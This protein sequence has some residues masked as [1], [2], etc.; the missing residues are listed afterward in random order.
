MPELNVIKQSLDTIAD[1]PNHPKAGAVMEKLGL[2][3]T[4]VNAWKAIKDNPQ[5]PKAAE[6]KNK[7]FDRIANTLPADPVKGRFEVGPLSFNER[8]DIKNLLDRDPIAAQKFLETRVDEQGNR[9]YVARVRDG[10]LE[11][12]K[13]DQ[14]VF[15]DIEFEG[16]DII[17]PFDIAFDIGKSLFEGAAATAGLIAGAPLG[18]AAS[19]AA[20]VT[21]G[22]AAGA[23]TE[24]LKQSIAKGMGLREDYDPGR[25]TQEAL[26]SGAGSIIGPAGKRLA[27]ATGG[28]IKRTAPKMVADAQAIKEAGKRLGIKPML[29]QLYDSDTVRLLEE[30]LEKT[31]GTIP[32]AGIRRQAKKNIEK[33]DEIADAMIGS[34]KNVDIVDVGESAKDSIKKSLAKRLEPIEEIY[35]N[36]QGFLKGVDDY[37]DVDYM[38]KNADELIG[39]H[40]FSDSAATAVNKFK[41]KIDQVDTLADLKEFRTTIF[42]DI[43]EAQAKKNFAEVR[44]LSD[45]YQVLTKARSRSLDAMIDNAP[46]KGSELAQAAKIALQKA[47][48]QFAELNNQVKAAI[49]ERGKK[50]MGSAKQIVDGFD[51]ILEKDFVRKM[52]NVNDPKRIK[53]FKQ[54]FPEAFEILREGKIAEISKASLNAK[55]N[56]LRIN[57]IMN[58]IEKMPR[59]SKELI[60]GEDA[61][62][63]VKDLQTLFKVMP[64]PINP[65][66]TSHNLMSPT[67]FTKA[68]ISNFSALSDRA[69]LSIL[70]NQASLGNFIEGTANLIGDTGA[71]AIARSIIRNEIP[72]E[73]QERSFGI[74]QF[75]QL[76][77]DKLQQQYNFGVPSK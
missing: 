12:R 62:R 26:I 74:P 49:V 7:I 56:S 30:N 51:E 9:K 34:A 11:V 53:L 39:K 29:R 54:E 43:K 33:L 70:T 76:N 72:T 66:G 32:G 58:R 38:K 59:A 22:T 64:P 24:G 25:I 73:A 31:L 13:P 23:F 65:S 21:A 50:A 61:I 60:F 69:R 20:A 63:K 71:V 37:I 41:N 15:Q 1:N 40:K 28:L 18:P 35:N 16:M 2:D 68:L 77:I 4:A 14:P 27:Q 57:T 17:D 75:E 67:G 5:H 8:F 55:T 19:G 42:N 36:V 52:L 6:V 47:D 10:K 3:V 44:A 48:K 46:Q 45:V